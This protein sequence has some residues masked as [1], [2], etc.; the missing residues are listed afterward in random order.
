MPQP[1]RP[2][3]PWCEHQSAPD[4]D[5][6]AH[7][8]F[9]GTVHLDGI[10]VD[11]SLTQEPAAPVPTITVHI[12]TST[13]RL[14]IDASGQQAWRLAGL[15]ID[16]T[17]AHA[18]ARFTPPLGPLADRVSVQPSAT[19][20]SQR[21]RRI[22][23]GLGSIRSRA[24]LNT[25]ERWLRRSFRCIGRTPTEPLGGDGPANPDNDDDGGR[26]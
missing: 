19:D 23:E 9:I 4:N 18:R 22:A 2:H 26:R 25:R 7:T 6:H 13:T 8:R 15:I 1:T 3:P 12:S 10:T 20:R 17:I 21:L 5:T 14:T 11:V 24:R 16:A